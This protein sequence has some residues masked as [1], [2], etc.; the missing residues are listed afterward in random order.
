MRLWKDSQEEVKRITPDRQ[1][2]KAILKMIEVRMRALGLKD[3]KEFA[4][5]AVFRRRL[6]GPSL[7]EPDSR[8]NRECVDSAGSEP[9][10]AGEPVYSAVQR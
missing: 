7:M 8:P 2:A 10:L 9:I 5:L 6:A 4:S 1:I 3:R